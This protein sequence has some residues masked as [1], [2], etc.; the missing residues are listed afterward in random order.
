[1]TGRGNISPGIP[2]KT[3]NPLADHDADGLNAL[4]E[5]RYRTHPLKHDTDRDGRPD[6]MEVDG[7][8]DPLKPDTALT[9]PGDRDGDAIP[10]KWEETFFRGMKPEEV[11]AS[12]DPDDDKLANF[13][14]YRLGTS[15]TR[16]DTDGNRIADNIEAGWRLPTPMTRGW[17]P[18]PREPDKPGIPIT[19]WLI[20]LIILVIILLFLLIRILHKRRR[21]K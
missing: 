4:E 10:D 19:W 15:P 5:F 9:G 14:E 20:L 3:I 7:K 1:M 6:G 11:D 18:V 8:T 21:K 13:T 12:G 16:W 2:I 17:H